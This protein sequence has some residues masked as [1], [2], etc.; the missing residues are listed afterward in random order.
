MDRRR[1]YVKC[2]HVETEVFEDYSESP[3]DEALERC[4]SHGVTG[5]ELELGI[6]SNPSG[7]QERPDVGELVLP[8]ADV[9]GAN[10]DYLTRELKED[11]RR[12]KRLGA[13]SL[14]VQEAVEKKFYEALYGAAGG[15]YT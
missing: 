7:H 15:L 13:L 4:R 9:F 11:Y 14:L 2:S 1:A 3:S 5:H 8:C 10:L 6:T 12:C